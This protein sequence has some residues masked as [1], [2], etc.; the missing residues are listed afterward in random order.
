MA[1]KLQKGSVL[2]RTLEWIPDRQINLLEGDCVIGNAQS[3]VRSFVTFHASTASKQTKM[4]NK[5]LQQGLQV[6]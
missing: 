5:F 6:C 3:K 4:K 2:D 1:W